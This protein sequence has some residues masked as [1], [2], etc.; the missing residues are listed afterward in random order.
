[1][2]KYIIAIVAIIILFMIDPFGKVSKLTSGKIGEDLKEYLEV[3]QEYRPDMEISDFQNGVLIYDGRKV[4]LLDENGKYKFQT[5]IRSDNFQMETSKDRVYILDKVMKKVEILDQ[6]GKLVEEAQLKDIPLNIKVLMNG[7]FLIHYSS[8]AGAEGISLYQKNGEKKQ[9]I[10]NPKMRMTFMKEDPYGNGF[11][12]SALDSRD[13]TLLNHIYYYDKNGNMVYGDEKKDILVSDV[14]FSKDMIAI[15]DPN[16]VFINN[17]KFEQQYR[18]SM[19]S[20]VIKAIESKDG[21]L[22]LDQDGVL[23]II[24]KD[25]KVKK[26]IIHEEKISEVE[27]SEEVIISTSG[28]TLYLEGSKKKREFPADIVKMVVISKEKV[29]VVFRGSIKFLKVV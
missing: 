4:K 10:L 6:D 11:F 9:D 23:K 18:V 13:K 2:K 29:A 27:T 7:N 1:M 14:V 12:L 16:Y 25:G 17:R 24:G 20:P 8:E 21:F 19:E 28:R 26:E 15:I 5:E 3:S 22:T